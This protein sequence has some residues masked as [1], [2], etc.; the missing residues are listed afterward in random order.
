MIGIVG[1]TGVVGKEL[2][3]LLVNNGHTNL[4]LC[5][6][7]RSIG[8]KISINENNSYIIDELCESFFDN[9]TVSF[10]CTDNDI[11]QKWANIAINKGVIV[12]DNSSAF[13]L[14]DNISLIIP[15][16]NSHLLQNKNHKLIAN[17]NCSTII[18]CMALFPLQKLSKIVRVDVSTYQA[19]SGAGQAGIDELS[20]QTLE[21]VISGLAIASN[22]NYPPTEYTTKVFKS[23]ILL[24]C[25]SHNSSIDL[26]SGYN[27]EELKIIQETI[28]ILDTSIEIS[29]T[30][31]RIPVMRA[32]CESVK[33]VFTDPVDEL[34]IKTCLF[35]MPGIK[36]LDDR[37]TNSFPEPLIAS[38][39]TDI[40][41]GRI[42]RDYFDDSGK[43]WHMFLCG[44][45]L[46]K[47]AAWNALQIFN[48]IK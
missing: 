12:I 17:P 7:E 14:D 46:L 39:K 20:N 13:R 6:S 27:G 24:N 40:F 47:G 31:V 5:A 21:F 25:F 16:I 28:K 4:K 35:N 3:T 1:A 15:E 43:T 19:V 10:F 29:A 11:S 38:G 48:I 8:T 18:L 42:R 34:S 2:L 44:D 33:I 9:M 23:Q 41:V 45:Q 26:E 30:C 37:E 32:H 22:K 36:L